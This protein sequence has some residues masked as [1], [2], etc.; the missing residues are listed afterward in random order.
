[1]LRKS[2]RRLRKIS[3]IVTAVFLACLYGCL[4]GSII[5][6]VDDSSTNGAQ[7][8]SQTEQEV[9]DLTNEE[10]T[11]RGLGQ[12]SWD[13][14]LAA[15]AQAHAEDMADRNYF[16]HYS[17]EGE[18]VA[19]RIIDQG[20]TYLT[21]GENIAYGQ[22]SASQVMDGW[23]NSEGHRANI[24]NEYFTEL[25]VGIASNSSGRIYWVQ[26]FGTPMN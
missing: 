24:L 3:F 12:L 1:M 7:Q 10:R 17:P 14:K 16:D 8:A 15:A 2:H 13:E 22:T 6:V 5:D 4:G 11:D 26:V 18:N 19:D 9:L 20:Y 21:A 25:G 23:M